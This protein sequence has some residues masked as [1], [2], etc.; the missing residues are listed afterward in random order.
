MDWQSLAKLGAEV[1]IVALFIGHLRH[2]G[3]SCRACRGE[4]NHMVVN[5]MQHETEAIQA[6]TAA[7]QKLIDKLEK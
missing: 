6:L 2:V 7:V 3:R 1:I 5:H 4:Q